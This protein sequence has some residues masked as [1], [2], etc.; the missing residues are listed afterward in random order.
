MTERIVDKIRGVNDWKNEM[1][2]LVFG[3]GIWC[4]ETVSSCAEYCGEDG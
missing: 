1:N 4:I 3:I 2:S